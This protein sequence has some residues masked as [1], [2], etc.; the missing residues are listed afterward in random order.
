MTQCSVQCSSRVQSRGKKVYLSA[1]SGEVWI[2]SGLGPH[3]HTG[4]HE[5]RRPPPSARSENINESFPLNSVHLSLPR[6][7]NHHLSLA[8]APVCGLSPSSILSQL[9]R[10]AKDTAAQCLRPNKRVTMGRPG[11]DRNPVGSAQPNLN[12]GIASQC[13]VHSHSHSHSHSV[14]FTQL[15]E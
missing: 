2:Y 1:V 14:Q 8:S 15:S 7:H 11:L 9:Q 10:S 3:K 6:G 5:Q 12:Q 4:T 13:S